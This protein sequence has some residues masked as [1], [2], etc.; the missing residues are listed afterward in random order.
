MGYYPRQLSTQPP[1]YRGEKRVFQERAYNG[2]LTGAAF[3]DAELA[4]R[5]YW[6]K[7]NAAGRVQGGRGCQVQAGPAEELG[8]V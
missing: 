8:G 4:F 7:E 1:A 2:I 6:A 3:M 5:L